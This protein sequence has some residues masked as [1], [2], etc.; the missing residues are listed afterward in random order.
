M[1]QNIRISAFWQDAQTPSLLS[2]WKSLKAIVPIVIGIDTL[3]SRW[4]PDTKLTTSTEYKTS[5]IL[6]ELSKVGDTDGIKRCS[7][8]EIPG[9]EYN[10]LWSAEIVIQFFVTVFISS[11]VEIPLLLNLIV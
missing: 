1:Q 5:I 2:P 6:H 3:G 8:K 7:V 4:Q 9:P 10:E 11:V